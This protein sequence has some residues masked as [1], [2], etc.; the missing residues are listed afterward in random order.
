MTD[1]IAETIDRRYRLPRKGRSWL[2]DKEVELRAPHQRSFGFSLDNQRNPPLAFFSGNPPEHIAKMCDAIVAVLDKDVL[3][4][5]IVEQK[6]MNSEEY[7]KQLT[8]GRLFC[9]WLLS[10]YR[11]HGYLSDQSV[12]FIGL[13]VWEPRK[14]P[15]K[16]T[17]SHRPYKPE[18]RQHFHRFF[19]LRN[20]PL[21]PLQKL[22]P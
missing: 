4:F 9:E 11:Y 6:T 10:L 22:I 8:N 13:L 15:G 14:S 18:K 7:I 19:D 3:Y 1:L 5:F 16:G 2:L 20:E 12:Q 17:T 21:I